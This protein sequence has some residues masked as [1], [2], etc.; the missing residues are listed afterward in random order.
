MKISEIIDY[1]N[2]LA[3]PGYAEDWDNVGLMIGSRNNKADKIL[4]CLDVNSKVIKEAIDNKV[5]LIIS[6][7]PFLFAKLNRI[8]FD[9]LKGE[10]IATLI[11]HNISVFSAHTNLDFAANGVNDTLA[12]T[13]GLTKCDNLKPYIPEGYDCDLGMG[14][15]GELPEKMNFDDFVASVKRNLYIENLRIIGIKPDKIKSAAIFCGSFDGDLNSVKR[16]KVDV[17]ITGDIKYHTALD[18]CEMG[19]CI[20]DVGHFAS[21]RLIV[22]KLKS[23]LERRFNNIE[24]ICSRMENDPFIY[25]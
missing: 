25:A 23:I 7:H 12:E 1:M 13:I 19:L 15:I 4:I 20:L 10:H 5:D 9:T 2:E 8:D 21:E 17:L 24:L 14:K 18:A 16:Q 6:H 3:P 11:K 22:N